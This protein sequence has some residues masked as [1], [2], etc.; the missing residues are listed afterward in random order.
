MALYDVK[1]DACGHQTEVQAPMAE[2]PPKKCP[3]CGKDKLKQVFDK[4][5]AFHS[6][7][8]PMHPRANRGRGH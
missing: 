2:G 8:S 5:A 3:E 6:H 7:L 1:C 4:I